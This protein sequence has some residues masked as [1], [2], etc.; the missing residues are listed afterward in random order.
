VAVAAAV[1]AAAVAP[2]AE[3]TDGGRIWILIK[4]INTEKQGG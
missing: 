4:L 2:D 1:E 3:G